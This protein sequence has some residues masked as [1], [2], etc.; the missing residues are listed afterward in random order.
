MQI[1]CKVNILKTEKKNNMRDAI[2]RFL[3]ENGDICHML[4]YSL[5]CF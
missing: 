1:I 3:I 2:A 4:R 5:S